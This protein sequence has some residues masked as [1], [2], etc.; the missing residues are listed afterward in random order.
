MKENIYQYKNIAYLGI[1]VFFTVSFINILQSIF[2][3][4]G[5]YTTIDDIIKSSSAVSFYL[6]PITFITFILV[7]FNNIRLIKREGNP[8]LSEVAIQM[9]VKRFNAP[10]LTLY[11]LPGIT[12]KDEE[13]FEKITNIITK[14]LEK[15]ETIAL[16]VY[17]SHLILIQM[18]VF[19]L[20]KL[21]LKMIVK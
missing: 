6:F 7:I 19:F 13:T 11:D 21:I 18:N 16:L 8:V 2:H 9:E 1:I 4:Q 3:Y 10:D 12:H 15:R 20:M 14:Y 17:S 5:L